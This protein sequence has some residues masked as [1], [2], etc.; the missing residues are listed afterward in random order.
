ML[1]AM[2]YYAVSARKWFKGPRVNVE[3]ARGTGPG[4]DPRVLEGRD[5]RN[6][7]DGGEG[8]AEKKVVES[9]V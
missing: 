2:V 6:P 7:G 1:L 3:H 9:E 5:A 4:F 8:G